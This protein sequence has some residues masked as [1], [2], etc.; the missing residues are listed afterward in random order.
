MTTAVLGWCT[1]VCSAQRAQLASYFRNKS[2]KKVLKGRLSL[3]PGCLRRIF[4]KHEAP[5]KKNHKGTSLNLGIWDLGMERWK[6][7]G[8]A[9]KRIW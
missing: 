3:S 8:C 4:L 2:F 9:K 6:V 5:G 1:T 7:W